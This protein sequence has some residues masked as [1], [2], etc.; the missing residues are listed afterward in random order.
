MHH[1]DQLARST[2]SASCQFFSKYIQLPFN[3][4]LASN[5]HFCCSAI[6]NP[7][8]LTTPMKP[9]FNAAI[10]QEIAA[11][12]FAITRVRYNAPSQWT[13]DTQAAVGCY[14]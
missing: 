6:E 11:V 8:Q 9:A 13:A 14:R 1:P 10:S 3:R 12:A 4:Q 7:L 5:V 2:F